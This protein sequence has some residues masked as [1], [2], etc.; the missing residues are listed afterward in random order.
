[1]VYHIEPVTA[2]PCVWMRAGLL[3]YKLCDRDFDCEHCPLDAALRGGPSAMPLPGHAPASPG[4]R[5]GTLPDDRLYSWGHT[6][7]QPI[8]EGDECLR[9]GLDG[10]ATSLIDAPRQVRWTP[11]TRPLRRGETICEIELDG[12]FLVLGTPVE[13]RLRRR[14]HALENDP[15]HLV[16]APYGDGWIAELVPA[17]DGAGDDLLSAEAAR[18]QA[19]MDRQRFWRKVALHLLAGSGTAGTTLADG[20]ELLTDLRQVLGGTLYLQLVRELIH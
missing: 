8:A 14:N 13:A 9:F 6:W 7:V 1:M 20:G 10:F 5:V 3:N 18:E 19:R 16:T 12:G 11:S 17:G 15:A 4:R 2:E